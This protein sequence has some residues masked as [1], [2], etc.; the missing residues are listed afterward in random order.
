ME[1]AILFSSVRMCS[2]K[3]NLLLI[4]TPKYFALLTV[5]IG[6]LLLERRGEKLGIMVSFGGIKSAQVLGKL[7]ICLH[8]A[9]S[10]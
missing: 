4:K 2:L 6:L 3:S 7:S 1:R 10:A 5:L 8:S 9:A